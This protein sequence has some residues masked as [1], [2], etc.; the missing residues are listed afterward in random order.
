MPAVNAGDC[1]DAPFLDP[2]T[3]KESA[4]SAYGSSVTLG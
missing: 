4:D 3:D 2:S 1:F